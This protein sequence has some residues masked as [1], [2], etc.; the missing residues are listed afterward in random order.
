MEVGIVGLVGRITIFPKDRLVGQ[1][2]DRGRDRIL[3][4]MPA[5]TRTGTAVKS[6]WRGVVSVIVAVVSIVAV[7]GERRIEGFEGIG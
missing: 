1:E 5:T 4:R 2:R 6:A 3:F 7:V